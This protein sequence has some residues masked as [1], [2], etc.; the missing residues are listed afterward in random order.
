MLKTFYRALLK[1]GLCFACVILPSIPLPAQTT[2]EVQ[3]GLIIP[4]SNTPWV[5]DRYGEQTQLVPIHHSTVSVNNHTGS[6]LTGS[7]VGSFFYK[8]KVTT[9]LNGTHSRNVVHTASPVIYFLIDTDQDDHGEGK[10]SGVFDFAVVRAVQNKGKRVLDRIAV[11]QLTGNTKHIGDAVD[12]TISQL[13]NSW[14]R[15]A[16][17]S[18]LEEGEYAL[19]PIP[20]KKNGMYSMVVWDFAVDP[21]APASKEA[22][23]ASG[24]TTSEATK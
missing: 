2:L 4:N 6:N 3:P 14:Y 20:K 11:T 18:P 22:I 24:T 1:V 7:A 13:P 12:V 16:P 9:E 23:L 8:P 10:S 21:K 19:L 5:V 15:I 17:K